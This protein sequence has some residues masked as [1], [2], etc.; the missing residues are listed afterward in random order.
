MEKTDH[1]VAGIV[2]EVALCSVICVV[3]Q[4]NGKLS[5]ENELK[6]CTSL[7]NVQT[8]MVGGNLYVPFV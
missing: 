7:R 1:L 6:M 3:V 8:V 2:G 4:E 5:I